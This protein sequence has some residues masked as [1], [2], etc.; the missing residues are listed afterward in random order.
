MTAPQ[1][2]ANLVIAYIS[3]LYVSEMTLYLKRYLALRQRREQM[4]GLAW[5]EFGA[6][7]IAQTRDV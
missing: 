5:A 7:V 3:L 4:R 2:R 1:L 6:R